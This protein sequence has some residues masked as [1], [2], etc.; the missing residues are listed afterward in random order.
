MNAYGLNGSG[1][2]TKSKKAG[3]IATPKKAAGKKRVVP[4]KDEPTE[5]EEDE[6]KGTVT[7]AEDV[8]NG[9]SPCKKTKVG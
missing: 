7:K 4:S 3:T 5:Y 2:A 6:S 1:K 9:E 8:E